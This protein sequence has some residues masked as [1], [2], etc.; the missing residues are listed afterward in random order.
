MLV[1]LLLALL[2]KEEIGFFVFMIGLYLVIFEQ[3]RKWG[4]ALMISGASWVILIIGV[5]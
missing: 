5:F 2:A 4:L 3:D 1:G